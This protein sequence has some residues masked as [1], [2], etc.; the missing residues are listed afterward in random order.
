MTMGA[1]VIAFSFAL[2]YLYRYDLFPHYNIK[3]LM[4]REQSL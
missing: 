2:I 3:H 4:P 1:L